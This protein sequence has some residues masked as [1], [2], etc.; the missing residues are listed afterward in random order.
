[1]QA[2]LNATGSVTHEGV[3]ST[4][5]TQTADE[6]RATLGI[7]APTAPDTP[8]EPEAPAEPPTASVVEP[9]AAP[10]NTDEQPAKPVKGKDAQKRIDQLTY[11]REEAKRE[12]ARVKNEYD[13][14]LRQFREETQ[15]E[16]ES[17]KRM[18]QPK[19][20]EPKG[21]DDPEPALE[22]F[23]NTD[24]PYASY[25]K[26]H[27]RWGA[28]QEFKSQQQAY[29]ERQQQETRARQQYER[30]QHE[31][32][33]LGTFTERMEGVF[34]RQPELRAELE[35]V[36]M[37][38]PMWDAVLDSE[39]PDQMVGYLAQHPEKAQELA[40]LP[41]LH[42]FKAMSRI[43]YELEAAAK[44]TGS[45]PAPKTTAHPPVSPVSGSH[46]APASGPPGPNATFEEHA[47]YYDRLENEQRYGARR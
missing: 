7:E 28:R 10:D 35:N 4:S 5:N 29:A 17:L 38:R 14:Q 26:A 46:S 15:R 8:A 1:M 42:A 24:D 6:M 2:P 23:A 30:E 34:S 21:D 45:A 18:A 12:W 36:A 11:E 13:R 31:R 22:Q 37:T 39:I 9:P 20:P 19:E 25:L 40:S 44:A 16:L 41:P 32:Q 3:T 33:R 47:A 27:A 43:E